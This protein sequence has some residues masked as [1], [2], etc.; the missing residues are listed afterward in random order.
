M[1]IKTVLLIIMS[2]LY[3][4]AGL[5]HFWHPFTYR[6]IIPHW[7]PDADALVSIS[8]IAEVIF[9]ILLIPAATRIAAAW[10]IIALLIAVFP[11]N[12]QMALDYRQQ[13]NPHLWIAIMRLPLQFVL[14]WWAWLY[15]RQ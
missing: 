14:I 5:N 10:C 11:A 9:G 13:H 12:I 15:T 8:G 2:L 3:V 7:L 6:K 1:I 4:A